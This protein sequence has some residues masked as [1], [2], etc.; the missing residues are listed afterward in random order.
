[1]AHHLVTKMVLQ[2]AGPPLAMP[3][4]KRMAHTALLQRDLQCAFARADAHIVRWPRAAADARRRAARGPPRGAWRLQT[5]LLA[6][7]LLWMVVIPAIA[8][9]PRVPVQGRQAAGWPP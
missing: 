2:F 6:P 5:M 1:M 3:P 4:P 9:E 7:L 8:L